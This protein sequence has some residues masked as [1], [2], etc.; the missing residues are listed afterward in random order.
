LTQAAFQAAVDQTRERMRGCVQV[1]ADKLGP[2]FQLRQQIVDR[3]GGA[4]ALAPS[5]AK[6]PI[7]SLDALSLF[8]AKPAAPKAAPTA[9]PLAA[10][11]AALLPPRFLETI[12]SERLPHLPRYLKALLLRVERASTNVLK[13]KERAAQVAPY[14][15]AVKQLA[16]APPKSD[17]GRKLAEDLRWMVEEFKVSL[18]AQELGTAQPVSPKRLDG[19]LEQIR[20]TR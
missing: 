13:E 11:L 19:L 6:A 7:K 12:P 17:E 16:T 18:F 10:E 8:S 20:M 14:A 9:N 1:L 5:S 2:L 4:A 3:L 15:A